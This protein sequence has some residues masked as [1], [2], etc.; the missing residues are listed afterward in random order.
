MRKW[1]I[2]NEKVGERFDVI[3]GAPNVVAFTCVL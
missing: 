1:R 2:L 3:F